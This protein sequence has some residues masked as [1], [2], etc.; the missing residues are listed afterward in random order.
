VVKFLKG[1]LDAGRQAYLVFPLVEESEKLTAQSAVAE[2]EKWAKRLSKF[3]VGLLTGRT[4]NDEKE[5]VMKRF[6]DG[7]IDVLVSTTVIEVG[8]DVPNAS[9]MIIHNANRFGLAQLHQLRGRIGRGEHQSFCV[10]ALDKKD[11]DS[12]TKLAILEETRDGFRIAEEDLRQRGPGDALGT[13]QSG[14]PDL[15]PAARAFIGDT[16]LLVHARELAE[17]VLTNDPELADP[18][19]AHLRTHLTRDADPLGSRFANVG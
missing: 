4:P 10:L 11:A 12:A 19:H 16:R 1:Q 2:F 8:V 15:S 13:A 18:A 7:H 9:V 14:L 6:R 17:R 3:E 5:A